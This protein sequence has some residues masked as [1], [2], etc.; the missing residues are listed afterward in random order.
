M[1]RKASAIVGIMA[2]LAV[3]VFIAAGCT[4]S[5]PVAPAVDNST[6]DQFQSP[7][8]GAILSEPEIDA[9]LIGDDIMTGAPMESSTP[10][11]H[12]YDPSNPYVPNPGVFLEDE[13][14]LEDV[15]R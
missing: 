2:T 5:N 7:G 15:T 8:N 1:K 6:A 13:I 12:E 10:G 11:I 14:S 4:G 9:D 3:L